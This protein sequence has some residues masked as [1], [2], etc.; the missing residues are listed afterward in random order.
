MKFVQEGQEKLRAL[1]DAAQQNG[2]AIDS[3]Q[4]V[5]ELLAAQ[6]Y[7]TIVIILFFILSFI[8]V[9]TSLDSAAF[10]LA[11]TASLNLSPDGQPPRWHRLVWAFVLSGTAL[12]LMYLGGL[13]ILQ[14]ASVVV[15]L[16]LVAVMAMMAMSFMAELRSDGKQ[17]NKPSSR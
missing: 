15:G 6:P 16:P 1:F 10:T 7:A 8:F 12:S 13:K 5:V 17:N 3:P 4:V 14:A 2:G 9:A 11:S